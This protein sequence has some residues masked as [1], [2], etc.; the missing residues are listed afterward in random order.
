MLLFYSGSP[1]DLAQMSPLLTICP[2]RCEAKALC[3]V[4]AFQA[5][6]SRAAGNSTTSQ[7]P[8]Q[9]HTQTHVSAN[10]G[11]E[12]KAGRGFVN[13]FSCYIKNSTGLEKRD[14]KTKKQLLNSN[15]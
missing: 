5:R 9:H 11:L 7:E 12:R 14:V 10:T 4:G 3:S 8:E 15:N 1:W 2:A 13:F 6:T